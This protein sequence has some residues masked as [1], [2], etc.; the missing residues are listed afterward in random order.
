MTFEEFYAD[1]SNRMLTALTTVRT[2]LIA[3][4]L[5]TSRIT[6]PA[7]MNMDDL[8]YRLT[9]NSGQGGNFR[10]IDMHIELTDGIHLPLESG[11]AGEAVIT[12]FAQTQAGNDVPSNY[13][14]GVLV[15]YS[16]PEGR[17]ALQVKMAELEAELP[18]AIAQIKSHL[19]LN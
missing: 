4:G 3:A 2:S 13:T 14:R 6:G 15:T 8:R 10:S 7:E 19:R 5:S 18:A 1:V 17:D 11:Q 9:A 12:L 16:T